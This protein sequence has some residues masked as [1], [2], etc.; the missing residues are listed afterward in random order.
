MPCVLQNGFTV[1]EKI[2][3]LCIDTQPDGTV[4]WQTLSTLEK[5]G[6]EVHFFVLLTTFSLECSNSTDYIT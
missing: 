6:K 2:V 1:E 3:F 5:K 4:M